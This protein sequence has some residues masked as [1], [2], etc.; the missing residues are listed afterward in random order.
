LFGA[1]QGEPMNSCVLLVFD[2]CRYD[3]MA[4]A[5]PTLRN[6]PR[7]GELQR[8]YSLSTWTFT[9]HI[10]FTLG[11]LPWIDRRTDTTQQKTELADLRLW[12]TRLG[13]ADDHPFQQERDL[14]TGLHRLGYELNAITS[15]NPLTEDSR[16][17]P[18]VDNLVSVG[19][20]ENCLERAL[21]KLDFSRPQ[22][23][24]I[25]VCETHY[26]YYD[27]GYDPQFS[28]YHLHG[29][30]AQMRAAAEDRVVT[31]PTYDEALL[32]TLR[33]RQIESIRYL[34][35]IMPKLF[36]ALPGGTYLTITADHGDCFGEDGFVGH[37]EVWNKM[38]LE[39]PFLEGR[40]AG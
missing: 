21:T 28:P 10:L 14:R 9:S 26:P 15:A 8:A 5:W 22:Y 29:F 11:R 12:K 33:L 20:F 18:F 4:A 39:V 16:F 40:V 35:A 17:R 34:D 19:Q 6:I 25:N 30:A 23:L 32:S 13:L 24:I 1:A 27:G 7:I 2:S 36:R 38:V 3:S 31:I 37:G